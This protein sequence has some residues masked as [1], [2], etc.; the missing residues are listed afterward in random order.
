MMVLRNLDDREFAQC[1]EATGMKRGHKLKLRQGLGRP[2]AAPRPPP[3]PSPPIPL[4]DDLSAGSSTEDHHLTSLPQAPTTAE[5][6]TEG[7]KVSLGVSADATMNGENSNDGLSILSAENFA[8]MAAE[9]CELSLGVSAD[10]TMNGENSNFDG[11]SILSAAS[12]QP[13]EEDTTML[14]V[15]TSSPFADLSVG[16]SHSLD[17]GAMDG[18]SIASRGAPL[19]GP[20]PAP[21]PVPAATTTG[22]AAIASSGNAEEGFK[23]LQ[24]PAPPPAKGKGKHEGGKNN[25]K[26]HSSH[27]SPPNLEILV[28]GDEDGEETE[29][30]KGMPST[31]SVSTT[32]KSNLA[33]YPQLPE[34]VL[35]V[36]DVCATDGVAAGSNVP[37]EPFSSDMMSPMQERR[38]S[39]ANLE[40][41]ISTL[42]EVVDNL[43]LLAYN[44]SDVGRRVRMQ[45]AR[46]NQYNGTIIKVVNKLDGETAFTVK[47]DDGDCRA[48]YFDGNGRYTAAWKG[49]GNIGSTYS[50]LKTVRE[51][52]DGTQLPLESSAT[53]SQTAVPS[54]QQTIRV[55][56]FACVRF[57]SAEKQLLLRIFGPASFRAP[58][59]LLAPMQIVMKPRNEGSENLALFATEFDIPKKWRIKGRISYIRYSYEFG[60]TQEV[61]TK[62]ATRCF[63]L[64]ESEQESDKELTVCDD[65]ILDPD[66]YTGMSG[67]AKSKQPRRYRSM[68]ALLSYFLE[69]LQQTGVDGVHR[70]VA[71]ITSLGAMGRMYGE[72]GSVQLRSGATS[73]LT[74]DP[75]LSSE[76]E[77]VAHRNKELKEHLEDTSSLP[78]LAAITR[79]LF[80]QRKLLETLHLNLVSFFDA[81]LFSFRASVAFR[82]PISKSL[83]EWTDL[84]VQ[85]S[86]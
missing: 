53:F 49:G 51:S 44:N 7:Y 58:V 52:T 30:S 22:W 16:D 3:P 59:N 10:A 50:I 73:F 5:I 19:S 1:A 18:D 68:K 47:Y 25:N 60:E 34:S 64:V 78:V 14:G 9:D 21:T 32:A 56:L 75:T 33:I 45:W 29:I 6:A 57:A 23:P 77:C 69:D 36:P 15:D 24:K 35:P 80:G 86:R 20:A 11:L 2:A 8:E 82:P 85:C 63:R 65:E 70:A 48:Y 67:M 39:S 72:Y 37:S 41:S 46:G 84:A 42:Q 12:I 55:K 40:T 83:V 79:C 54:T 81:V 61:F 13:V 38:D 27:D 31:T 26:K 76:R 71:R 62:G 17:V 74:P 28:A 4:C 43:A 66:M